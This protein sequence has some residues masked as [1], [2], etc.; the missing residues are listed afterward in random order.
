MFVIINKY[1]KKTK[2]L[3][4]G[5]KLFKSNGCSRGI[6]SVCHNEKPNR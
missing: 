5:Y 6:I 3:K 2:A 4:D 1:F